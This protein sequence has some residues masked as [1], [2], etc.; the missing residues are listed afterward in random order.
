MSFT[1]TESD[2]RADE[3]WWCGG[4]LLLPCM[5]K[6]MV[7]GFCDQLL[8]SQS[9]LSNCS[10]V[11]LYTTGSASRTGRPISMSWYPCSEFGSKNNFGWRSHWD[12]GDCRFNSISFEGKEGWIIG[13]PAILLHTSNSGDTWERIP[14]SS[15]LPGN[16]VLP[17]SWTRDLLEFLPFLSSFGVWL[18]CSLCS[19][20]LF[21]SQWPL[22][23]FLTLNLLAGCYKRHWGEEC[24]DGDRW[25][26]NL[27]NFKQGLQLEGCCR[28]NC[29]S[30]LE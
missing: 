23:S 4:S 25:R 22:N 26:C 7:P 8:W 9:V 28:R 10:P 6:G 19:W 2:L 12:E 16:P 15:R 30:Y 17:R 27:H 14:L 1:S 11:I 21:E 20:P 13:K 18:W 24:R 29:F 3:L 5:T